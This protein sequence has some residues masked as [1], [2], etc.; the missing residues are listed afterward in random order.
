MGRKRL[1]LPGTQVV[2]TKCDPLTHRVVV[3]RKD[4]KCKW[5]G[6]VLRKSALSLHVPEC[7]DK[8]KRIRV[9]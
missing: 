1:Y 8:H 9:L 2:F 4:G 5:C 7:R 3:S 6:V